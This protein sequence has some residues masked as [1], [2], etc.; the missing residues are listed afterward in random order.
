MTHKKNNSYLQKYYNSRG[1]NGL[2]VAVIVVMF[3]VVTSLL[4]I[5]AL[6][7]A[8]MKTENKSDEIN[9]LQDIAE[10]VANSLYELDYSDELLENDYDNNDLNDTNFP[11]HSRII[12]RVGEPYNV[13]WN[14]IENPPDNNRK[15]I[16]IIVKKGLEEH[17][18]IIVIEKSERD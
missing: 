5:M 14:I 7:V 3:F 2:G 12:T 6:N 9:F 10:S 1:I 4:V 8:R 15:T 16:K 17:H 13:F 11:D 18:T